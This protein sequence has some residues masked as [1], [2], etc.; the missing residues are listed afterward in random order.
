MSEITQRLGKMIRHWRVEQEMEQGELARKAG[1][2]R[3]ELGRIERG[4][5]EE[6]KHSTIK[7]LAD[8]LRISINDLWPEE[9]GQKID[10][11]INKIVED[12]NLGVF[13][14]SKDLDFASH[15][16][17]KNILAALKGARSII[18][19]MKEEN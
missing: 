10:Q 11:D 2:P 8:V 17:K 12:Y 15:N 9:D 19:K 13:G 1:V 5:I 14:E 7:K 16:V 3:R 4:E 18:E 6:P